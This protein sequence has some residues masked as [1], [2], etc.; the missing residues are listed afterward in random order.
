MENSFCSFSDRISAIVEQGMEG[1]L[2]ARPVDAKISKR[3]I[4]NGYF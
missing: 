4:V 2:L 1:E 3:K